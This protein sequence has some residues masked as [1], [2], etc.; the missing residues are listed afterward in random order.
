MEWQQGDNP[1]WFGLFVS[2]M[3][4]MRFLLPLLERERGREREV[5]MSFGGDHSRSADAVIFHVP[6]MGR[7]TLKDPFNT[8]D[9]CS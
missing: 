5:G 2:S 1:D 3:S 7:K 8:L 9:L 6:G 4:I